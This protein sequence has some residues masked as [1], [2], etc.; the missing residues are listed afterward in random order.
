MLKKITDLWPNLI[1]MPQQQESNADE[2]QGSDQA[3]LLGES[4]SEETG[5]LQIK[6]KFKN[7][8]WSRLVSIERYAAD[9]IDV[10]GDHYKKPL[11]PDV[12][13]EVQTVES[14][15]RADVDQWRPLFEPNEFNEEH[16]PL[17][18][19]DYQIN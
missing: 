3:G 11:V 16:G 15:D 4:S 7:L 10:E 18:L 6:E 9:Q 8:Y 13:E 14:L 5:E 1:R 19:V 12:L 17:L 2:E